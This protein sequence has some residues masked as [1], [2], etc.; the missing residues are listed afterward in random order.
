MQVQGERIFSWGGQSDMIRGQAR[1]TPR[2]LSDS[3]PAN[4]HGE[5]VTSPSSYPG[6]SRSKFKMDW[7]GWHLSLKGGVGGN[8]AAAKNGL[9]PM[10][11]KAQNCT[12]KSAPGC[13]IHTQSQSGRK[14]QWP[15]EDQTCVLPLSLAAQLLD[16][17]AGPGIPT[18]HCQPT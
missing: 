10:S 6:N 2:A 4:L 8:R 7:A 11:P 12:L 1:V 14:G 5:P 17:R 18:S 3:T 13:W 15:A 16:C 9:W